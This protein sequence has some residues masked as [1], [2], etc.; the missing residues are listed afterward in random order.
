M[1]RK[2]RGF[3]AWGGKRVAKLEMFKIILNVL[4]VEY[5]ALTGVVEILELCDERSATSCTEPLAEGRF[6][7]SHLFLTRL[8]NLILNKTTRLAVYTQSIGAFFFRE[9]VHSV[10]SIR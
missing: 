5:R 7:L 8:V 1:Y 2:L 3:C 6:A 9:E 4:R 10:F